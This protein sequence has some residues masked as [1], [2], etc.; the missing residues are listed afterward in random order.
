ME[1]EHSP[2]RLRMAGLAYGRCCVRLAYYNKQQEKTRV[3][4]KPTSIHYSH[5]K[6]DGIHSTGPGP[7]LGRIV[8]GIYPLTLARTRSEYC[9]QYRSKR[10]FLC[11]RCSTKPVPLVFA[12]QPLSL[13]DLHL[14]SGH[15]T[16]DPRRHC[17]RRNFVCPV[18]QHYSIGNSCKEFG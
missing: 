8:R 17:T 2:H 15:N 12:T 3:W 11:H 7:F 6:P 14:C 5:R 13:Q 4:F 1:E 10:Q 9:H 18:L 16:S